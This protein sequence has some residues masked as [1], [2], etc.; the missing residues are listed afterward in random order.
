MTA[1]G[2]I[3]VPFH[4]NLHV[5]ARC[6]AALDDRP[7]GVEL[8]IVS[9]GATEDCRPLAGAHGARVVSTPRQS[10]A[11]AARNLGARAAPGRV[12]VFVDAD[13]VVSPGSLRRILAAVDDPA[14]ADAVFGAYDDQP[15]DPGF[16]SQYKNLSHAFVHRTSASR[17]RTF[18]TGFGAVRRDAFEA[19][20]GF[21]DRLPNA[22]VEDI[23]LGYR[24]SQAGYTIVLDSS[25]SACHL[26][27]WTV[28]SVIM[29]DV[30]DR[31]I[32][33]TQLILKYGGMV[34]DLNV[35]TA[36]R[37]SVVL[38]YAAL[39]FAALTIYDRRFLAGAMIATIVLTLVHRRYYA[40]FYE[41]RG[42]WFTARAWLLHVAHHLYNGVSFAAGVLLFGASRYLGLRLP[43]SIP[44]DGWTRAR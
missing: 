36:Y 44:L 37:W 26:K 8:L 7:D 43:G 2:T 18:W 29:S 1:R 33:W 34:D 25:L 17:A 42:A 15:G 23:D 40:F 5:L 12:L 22:T 32:P 31:G 39:V 38:A 35:K 10:G 14:G 30:F 6:L 4:R 3:V 9:D 41:R 13:V 16:V 28:R 11:A 21:D 24:L 19:V 20:G 27:R